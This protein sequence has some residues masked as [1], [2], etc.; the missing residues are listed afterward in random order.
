MV[1]RSAQR[2]GNLP[3]VEVRVRATLGGAAM[4]GLSRRTIF[5]IA[6]A[7]LVLFAMNL[8]LMP[9]QTLQTSPTTFGVTEDGYKAAYLLL[10]EMGLPVSRS[11]A[12]PA[13]VSPHAMMWLVAPMFLNPEN[14]A[15][16]KSAKEVL[17]WVRAGGTAVVFG[18]PKSNWKRLGIER[19]TASSDDP[20]TIVS[21]EWT[22]LPRSI[23]VAGLLYFGSAND[24]A[25]VRLRAG[26]AAFA[27][28]I[29]AGT[30][31]I[32]AVADDRFLR[33]LNL[34]E[35]DNSVLLVELAHALGPVVF[36]ERCH[37]L[38]EP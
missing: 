25:R 35:S 6:A 21:G 37:G 22:R 7:A 3:A 14:T 1:R 5:M 20:A 16:E 31:K 36:D 2:S 30:G 32:V 38:A 8:W 10:S 17:Q 28:E 15:G 18:A 9:N 26:K 33:N 19:T 12:M 24:H 23:K 27:I 4:T 29:A 34:A 13:Q 11:Y